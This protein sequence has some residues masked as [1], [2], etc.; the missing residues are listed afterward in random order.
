MPSLIYGIPALLA[1]NRQ[2]GLFIENPE[3]SLKLSAISRIL[4]ENDYSNRANS[5]RIRASVIPPTR[6]AAMIP[7]RSRSSV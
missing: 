6:L 5:A 3:E 2:H 1:A 4:P 7:E